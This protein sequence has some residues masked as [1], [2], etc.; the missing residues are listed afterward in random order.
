MPDLPYD[1]EAKL[2]DFERD[3]YVVLERVIAP[4]RMDA[5]RDALDRVEA[6]N[7]I[8]FR[9]TDFEGR[10]TVRI[11]NL[12]AYD[13]AFWEVPIEPVALAFAERVL[14]PELQLSS[15]SA[16]TLC[17]G[18]GAQP[19]HADDQ[20]IPVPKPH[21]PFTL[22]CVWALSDFTEENGATLLVPGSHKADGMP[23][24]DIETDTV[25]GVMP[26]GSLIFWH[27][28]FWHAGGQ[29]RTQA[30]RYALANYYC[31]GFVRQ[32]EN[33]QLGVPLEMARRFPKR[34]KELCGYS[35][36]RGLYGHVDNVDPIT[37]LGESGEKLIWQRG[38]DEM[39]E[40]PLQ[41]DAPA[42]AK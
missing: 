6:R 18:Q 20:L 29:N 16:I 26:K 36:Y 24:F 23:D 3:G 13:E 34:L 8:G 33:Q 12:L 38:Y 7:K 14:D 39:Y 15:L 31:A 22:N 30:R 35:A 42:P 27:G 2:A 4:E 37:M 11:Y 17:P 9:D 40:D 10:N 19:L 1:L 41:E 21:Q 28:S 25:P 32:Q 5:L